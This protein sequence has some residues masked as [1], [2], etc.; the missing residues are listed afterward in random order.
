MIWF[1]KISSEDIGVIVEKYPSRPIPRR[2]SETVSV[3]GRNGDILFQQN[4]FENVTQ[5][6]DIYVSA[7][8]IKL[9]NIAAKV[10]AWL[11]QT[12]YL[13]LE[14]SYEPDI[15]RM[16]YY[17]GGI[18]IENLLD[19]Y[20]RCTI[21]F[22]CRP[23]RYLKTGEYPV[24]IAKNQVLINPT[25]YAAKPLIK[26]SGTGDGQLLVG[27][28]EIALKGINGYLMIDSD[29]M[30]CYKGSENCNAK[31]TGDFPVLSGITTFSWTG[32]ITGVEVTPRWYAI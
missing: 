12:G 15:Y 23:E 25:S 14:D 28:N 9:H 18:D 32:G 24:T 6:Y 1:N 11:L 21:T 4:A 20:G 22:T 26:V 17:S 8:D 19:E 3:P 31:M 5:S 2:K 10:A 13:R 7:K 29:M 30:D 27:D 16:A